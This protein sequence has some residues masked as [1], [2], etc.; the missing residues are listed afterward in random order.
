MPTFDRDLA[1]VLL[2]IC[3]YTYAAG[4]NSADDAADKKE[5]LM[6]INRAGLVGAPVLVTEN[7]PVPTSVACVSAFP[8]KNIVSYMGTKTEFDNRVDTMESIADWLE[9][10]KAVLVPFRLTPEQAGLENFD[11]ESLRGLVHAGFLEELVA[12]HAQ[13]VQELLKHDG[14]NRPLLVT[15]HSQG[16]AEA[17]LATQALRAAGFTVTATYTFAAP[18][19]GDADF[20]N[21]LPATL[22]VHRLEFGDD[23]V[24]HVPPAM[25]SA[26]I[27]AILQAL[28][29]T[30]FLLEP[31]KKLLQVLVS[32]SDA[33]RF[34]G[35]GSL[36]YGNPMEQVLHVDLSAAQEEALVLHRLLGLVHHPQNW[37]EHHHL[38][39]T[40]DEVSQGIKGN[41]TALVSTYQLSP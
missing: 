25:V 24:P 40:N 33:A 30:P 21:S 14:Q 37:G 13:V 27:Q 4:M 23:I 10:F 38:A 17:A 5:S 29:K 1:R 41:Y 16:G 22:P 18:R 9:N 32:V 7:K 34:K 28:L 36:C 12:V 19:P 15:G 20:A 31:V 26:Q 3:R 39:G 11:S 6:W 8:D 2:E 35:V